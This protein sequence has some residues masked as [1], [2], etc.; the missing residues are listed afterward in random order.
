MTNWVGVRRKVV[1][2]LSQWIFVDWILQLEGAAVR[3]PHFE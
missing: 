2:I 3:T 1:S